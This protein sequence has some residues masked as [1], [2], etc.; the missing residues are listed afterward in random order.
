[1]PQTNS[2]RELLLALQR[3]TFRYFLKEV[4]PATGLMNDSTLPGSNA[5]I[6]VVG[7]GL[8]A[9]IVGVE[10]GLMAHEEALKR[11]LAALRFF[12]NSRQGTEPDA[13]GY[14]GFYYHFLERKTGRRAGD[15]ELSP[16]DTALLLAGFL[17]AARYFDG[18]S[19]EERELR[20]LVDDLYRRVEWG[21]MLNDGA[22]ISNGWR[23]ESGFLPY[24]WKGYSEGSLIYLLA[25]GSPT[26]PISPACWLDWTATYVWRRV[27]D[28][29]YLYA[30]PLFI[31]QLPHCWIDFRSI[32][33]LYMRE[34]G[35]DYFENSRRATYAQQR[36]AMENP[37][38]FKG[39][40]ETCWGLTASDGPGPAHRTHEGHKI[41]YYGYD[42]RG[43]P[44]GPDDGTIAPAAA[45]ASLP[46][47]PEIVLPTLRHFKDLELDRETDYGFGAAFND[48]FSS[49]KGARPGWVANHVYGLNQGPSVIMIENYLSGLIWRLMRACPTL[50]EGLRRAG[51]QGGWLG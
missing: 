31:H 45:V 11:T 8:T 32:Q 51:F 23:P 48:T 1:M 39:Y 30:G 50:Q 41:P 36:Y 27:Y 13:T 17:A 5:S 4:N 33:D 43:I 20:S 6:A 35:I 49:S 19:G 28:L 16:I 40:G 38:H 9:Y 29:E 18:A 12:Q 3:D 47:A 15:C 34:K 42:A 21:W 26:H 24:N 22:V 25:L 7:L 46:F 37:H 14:K 10:R 44:D 2:D